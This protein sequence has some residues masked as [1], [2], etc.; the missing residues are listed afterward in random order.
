MQHNRSER[1]PPSGMLGVPVTW[2][3][4][5]LHPTFLFPTSFFLTDI[6]ECQLGMHTCGENTTCTNMEGNY[7][8][9]CASSLSEPGQ[10]CPGRL[11]G[12]LDPKGGTRFWKILY[13]SLFAFEI[14]E[15]IW[16]IPWLLWLSGL[17]T[18]LQTKGLQVQFPVRAHA[19][20]AG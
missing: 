3:F 14:L 16:S 2:P 19:W 8:C 12:D 17:S 1:C 18:G 5:P 13:P 15:I 10:N 20:V 9:M 4:F 7:T 11:V 6:D